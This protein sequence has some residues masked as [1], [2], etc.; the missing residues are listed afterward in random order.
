MPSPG[1]LDLQSLLGSSV[2]EPVALVERRAPSPVR[3]GT[4]ALGCPVDRSLAA[5]NS[6]FAIVLV[7]L[8]CG[9]MVSSPGTLFAQTPS[10]APNPSAGITGM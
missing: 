6:G 1:K 5:A 2:T 9:L 3:A 7:V 10:P 8:L 4:A